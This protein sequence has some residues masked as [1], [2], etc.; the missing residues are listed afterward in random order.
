MYPQAP[1]VQADSD[2]PSS[3]PE[4]W[5]SPDWLQELHQIAA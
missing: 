3:L 2:Y 4:V 5:S 1:A